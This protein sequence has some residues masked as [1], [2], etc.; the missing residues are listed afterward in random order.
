MIGYSRPGRAS[1]WLV[2]L[3]FS[4]LCKTG[5]SRHAD[6]RRV[7]YRRRG[8]KEAEIGGG[9]IACNQARLDAGK[10]FKLSGKSSTC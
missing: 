4:L 10:V 8:Q 3:K 1:D 7:K 9:G 5:I 2:I 6:K